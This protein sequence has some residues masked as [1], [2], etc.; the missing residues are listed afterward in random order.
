[1][2]IKRTVLMQHAVENIRCDPSRRE[3]GHLGW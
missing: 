3:T 1:L 2:L